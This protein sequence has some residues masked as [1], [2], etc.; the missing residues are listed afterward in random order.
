M[1]F[2]V[3]II[4]SKYLILAEMSILSSSY[5]TPIVNHWRNPWHPQLKRKVKFFFYMQSQLWCKIS[6]SPSVFLL[7]SGFLCSH[8]GKNTKTECRWYVYC[9]LQADIYVLK[10]KTCHRGSLFPPPFRSPSVRIV[11]AFFKKITKNVKNTARRHF[12]V[13]YMPHRVIF[14]HNF[15][16]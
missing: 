10:C 13:T 16:Q 1:C 12:S 5:G 6:L 2:I 4:R 11:V 14:F 3:L 8:R 9:S 7:F 15:A